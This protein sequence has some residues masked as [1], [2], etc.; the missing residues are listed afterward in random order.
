MENKEK[1]SYEQPLLEEA[2]FG[3]FVAGKSGETGAPEDNDP[4]IGGGF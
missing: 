1:L 2:H 3:T 4:G